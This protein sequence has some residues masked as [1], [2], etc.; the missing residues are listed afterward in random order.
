MNKRGRNVRG[1]SQISFGMIFSIILI[2]FFVAFAIFGINKFLSVQKLAQ[3]SKF[4]SD[5][6]ADINKMWR[7]T[8]GSQSLVYYIPKGIKQACFVNNRPNPRTL[9]TEN[10][11]FMPDD[12]Y[13]FD[14]YLFENVNLGKTLS[15]ATPVTNP[16]KLCIDIVN[17]KISLTIK[18]DYNENSVTI[19]K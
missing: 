19:I 18:K 5:F 17:G 7:S 9:K 13:Q 4:K 1:Q 3:V 6:Q 16:R 11:Y 10:M 15:L 14:G 8:Q 2:V 12:E